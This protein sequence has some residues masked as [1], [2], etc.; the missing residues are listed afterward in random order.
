MDLLEYQGKQLFARHGVP[1][2]P[3]GWP[4]RAGKLQASDAAAASALW[5]R[6]DAEIVDRA[7]WIPLVNPSAIQF[8]SERVGNFQYQ[9]ASGV[10]LEQLWVR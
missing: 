7:P 9:I 10:L 2:L 3:R 4:R 6:I 8:L 5:T 1:I